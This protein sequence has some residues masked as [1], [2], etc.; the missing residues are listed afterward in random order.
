MHGGWR[1][2]RLL[3]WGEL[4]GLGAPLRRPRGRPARTPRP[5]PLPFAADHDAL[6]PAL[7]QG[8]E[9]LEATVWL[10]TARWRPLGADA[11][12]SAEEVALA[13][14]T[15]AA[16]ALDEAAATWL[17]SRSA[18]K[19]EL[20]PATV[21][22]TDLSYWAQVSRWAATLVARGLFLPAVEPAEAGYRA[23][24]QPVI[25]GAD[26]ARLER[27]AGAMPDAC[28]AFGV[29]GVGPPARTVLRRF[30]HL[31]VD[32]M[33]REAA[34]A[35]G[36]PHTR[37]LHGRW[38]AA[39]GAADGRLRGAPGE[40][41]TLARQV[42]EWSEPVHA[43]DD[44]VAR[45][46]FRLEEPGEDSA[47]WR[48]RYLLQ[49][50]ADPSLQLAAEEVWRLGGRAA[51]ASKIPAPRERLLAALGRAARL[52]P[53][54]EASLAEPRPAGYGLDAAGAHAFLTET[55]SLLEQAGF[56]VMLPAWWT[57]TGTR[58]RVA[59][60]A[61]VRAP[62]VAVSAGL[63][64][65]ALLDVDWDVVLDGQSLSREELIALA[66]LKTP[67]VRV[68]GQWVELRADELR[69]ALSFLERGGPSR[70]SLG[71]VVR[72]ALGATGEVRGLALEAVHGDG[73][74]GEILDRLEHG[75]ALEEE[76]PPAGL[77]ATLRPYQLRGYAWLRFLTRW[78]LG[79]C[80]ADD[81]GLGKTVQTLAVVQHDWAQGVRQPVL[82]VC[83]TSVVGN[84]Q[85]EAARF[86]PQLP[87]LVH[88]G[89][90]RVRD[91]ERFAAEAS[92]RALVVSSYALLQ[93]DL[94]TLRSVTWRGVVLDEAQN[95]KNAA[96][97][98][99]RAARALA[100]S[101]RIALTGTP[102]ENHV[103]DLWALMDFLNPGLLGGQAEFQRRFF[104]P[105]HRDGDSEARAR[106][107]RLTGPLVL[108]RLKTDPAIRADLPDKLEMKVYC[109]LT[110]EQASLYAA[111][112]QDL[113]ARIA[114]AQGMSRKGLI[115][116][117]LSKLKQVC[118]HPAHFLG[119]NSALAGRSGKL[120][121]LE[122]MLEEVLAVGERALVF[123]QFAEMGRL[124]HRRLAEVFGR[125]V[126]F[127]H[128][129]T[130]KALR[131][132]MVERF[133]AAGGGPPIF[134]L[135][136]KAGGTGVNLTRASHVFHFDRWWNPAVENQATDRAFRL[137][138][139]RTVEVHTFICSGTLEERIDALIESKTRVAADVV[140]AGETW[141][142]ELSTE[143]IREL[144]RLRAE[145]V[146]D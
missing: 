94:E 40:L 124:L 4:T 135:S 13:P 91:A 58:H 33:V 98:Q 51:L 131:D 79:A 144:F 67:L 75:A 55:A 107:K 9:A 35:V 25:A 127:M 136:L 113:E 24:W 42:R 68:R 114:D 38:L 65:D 73:W 18:P 82:L 43:R 71:E 99:A 74:V 70:A 53:Q 27:L 60:S 133:Q 8:A 140:D 78:G 108:R 130:P 3:V 132:R 76:P 10:P 31:L 39:L 41:E 128:G 23:T 83:P 103:G 81:M 69:A 116:A 90:G 21:A 146:A 47:P 142:T 17:L 89:L 115:L 95:V 63:G 61:R 86:T 1:E 117:T 37:D 120:E 141:L 143:Q 64:V 109:P 52:V 139:D 96:T 45:L 66:R 49:A 101:Y 6:R 26:R 5:R 85:R 134:V 29:G 121:R 36:P 20:A 145:A 112:T 32:R 122:E 2:D 93:R 56:G 19:A 106:L 123:T 72:M 80:L 28:R 102:V 15:V 59:V 14:W 105:I 44:A 34:F 11:E 92:R 129:G 119:D 46:C 104:L 110:A 22:G 62:R 100:A 48:V 12:E 7:P 137:G 50:T 77:R 57:R 54:V 87:V 138:Q 97:K 88:H 111:V 126:L 16:F 30:V 125:E 84:W 118:N